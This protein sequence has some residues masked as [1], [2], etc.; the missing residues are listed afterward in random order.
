VFHRVRLP[1]RLGEEAL[2]PLGETVL[3][4]TDRF[5]VGERGE[6]LVAFSRQEQAFK[7]A[8]EGVTL[9][10]LGKARVEVLGVGFERFGCG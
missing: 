2:K 7:I 5:G 10:A 1:R 3:G 6:G 4:T 8:T 9:I